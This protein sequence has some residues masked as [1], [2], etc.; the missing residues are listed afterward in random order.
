M[1]ANNFTIEGIDNNDKSV[2]GPMVYIPND[3]VGEFMPIT[4]QFSPEFGHSAGVKMKGGPLS[5]P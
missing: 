5:H 1:R 4:N 3:A 2:T